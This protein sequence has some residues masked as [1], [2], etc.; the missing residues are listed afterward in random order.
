MLGSR[1]IELGRVFGIGS[2]RIMAIE[3]LYCAKMTSYVIGSYS[4][5]DKS[6]AKIRLV[7]TENPNVCGTVNCKVCRIAIALYCL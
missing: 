1:G 7:K 6:V 3:E 2:C 4:E 5:T